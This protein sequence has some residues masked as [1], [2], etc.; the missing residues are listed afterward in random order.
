MSNR[1]IV[2]LLA[3]LLFPSIASMQPE[4]GPE[5]KQPQP[6]QAPAP[7]GGGNSEEVKAR[8]T[9]AVDVLNDWHDAAAHADLP[10]YLSHW[11]NQSVFLG[12]D[13]NERWAGKE[14]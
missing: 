11:T 12:T 4:K 8:A 10:R 1:A 6:P 2:G 3:A 13:A 7:Q 9:A 14:F 5:P